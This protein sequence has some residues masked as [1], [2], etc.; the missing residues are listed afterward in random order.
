MASLNQARVESATE[1][2]RHS[3]VEFCV[4]SQLRCDRRVH[5]GA[6]HR[7][8]IGV[9]PVDREA[10]IGLARKNPP[11]EV[12]RDVKDRVH[13][14]VLKERFRLDAARDLPCGEIVGCQEPVREAVAQGGGVLRDDRDGHAFDVHR[15]AVAEEHEKKDRQKEPDQQNRGIP[16]D[17]GAFLED[18]GEESAKTFHEDSSSRER[19]TISMKAS[20]IVGSGLSDVAPARRTPSGVPRMRTRPRS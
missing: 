10:Q 13:F 11:G 2:Q 5:V 20:S 14:S 8:L 1:G 9:D 6:D 4:R 12:A 3:G 15:K 17:L 19:S 7:R 18:H 16:F